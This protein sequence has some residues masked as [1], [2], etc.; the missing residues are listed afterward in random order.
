MNRRELLESATVFV[1]AVA[2]GQAAAADSGHDMAKMPM[3]HDHGHAQ[4]SRNQ[5]LIDAAADCVVKSNI[6]FQH[7]LVLLGAGDL[8]LAACA[9]TSSQT[10]ALCQALLQ[11]ATAESKYLPQ[12]AKVAMDVCKA[13]E[14]ECKKTEK[15]PECMACKEACAACYAQCKA[16]AL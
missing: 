16:I 13:C 14:E 7:C 2:A 1:A 8:E 15:H 6:C 12:L 9:K 3:N 10:A 4:A 5:A 11:M